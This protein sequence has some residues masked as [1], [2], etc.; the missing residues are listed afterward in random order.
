MSKLLKSAIILALAAAAG[1]ASAQTYRQPSTEEAIIQQILSSVIGTR[2]GTNTQ[3]RTTSQ[4]E[5]FRAADTNRD[6]ILTQYEVDAYRARMGYGQYNNGNGYDNGY[7]NGRYDNGYNNG[8]YNDNR[9]NR[10][11]PVFA[12]RSLDT[13]RD[14]YISRT[15][16]RQFLRML[17][18][19]GYDYFYQD[20]DGRP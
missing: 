12:V 19:Q 13:N 4:Q 5:A 17:D 20:Y 8:R 1:T 15:E 14:G 11:D 3:Y 16:F 2:Y 10:R 7:N 9:Y 18:S 6:G